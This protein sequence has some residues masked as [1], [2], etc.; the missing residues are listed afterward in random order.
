VTYVIVSSGHLRGLHGLGTVELPPDR[1]AYLEQM[2]PIIDDAQKKVDAMLAG[3]F[4]WMNVESTLLRSTRSIKAAARDI[5]LQK[6]Q[7]LAITLPSLEEALRDPNRKLSEIAETMESLFGDFDQELAR[8]A[9]MQNI[10]LATGAK[11]AFRKAVRA[12]F[13]MA[14]TVVR[15]GA[16]AVGDELAESPVSTALILGAVGVGLFLWVKNR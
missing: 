10:T 9:A 1:A 6:K 13:D 4:S 12:A 8:V 11:T 2:K 3:D 15:E 7:R 14:R 16:K 5:L